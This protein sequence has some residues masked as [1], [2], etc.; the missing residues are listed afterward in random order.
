[1]F[2][3]TGAL[4]AARLGVAPTA[5]GFRHAIAPAAGGALYVVDGSGRTSLVGPEGGVFA[6]GVARGGLPLALASSGDHLLLG[7]DRG[8]QWSADG[9]RT[10][11]VTG[12]AGR[13]PAVLVEGDTALAG[14][15]AGSLE[16]TEDGGRS[17]RAVPTPA[18]H[19]FE[20]IVD[21][22][23]EWYVATLTGVIV[24][25]DRGAS[26]LVASRPASRATA[27]RAALQGVVVGTWRGELD[28]LQTTSAQP[29]TD[30]HAGIWALTETLVA[31][32]DG[33]RGAH[34][35]TPLDHAEVTAL[36]SSGS[37]V[38]AGVARGPLYRSTDGG[39]SWSRVEL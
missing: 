35:G 10:W 19:E 21:S 2:V 23:G 26:W 18:S 29:L 12:P 25:V 16:L 37:A 33:L 38:Y 9:G 17:W 13:F 27:L 39:A 22:G 5:E 32:T 6:R 14:G 28:Q 36:V 7:T 11:R 34:P 15:W 1:M 4:L 30:V 24:S 3:F 31:T 8:L 20:A